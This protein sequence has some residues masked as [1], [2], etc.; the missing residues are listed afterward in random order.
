MSREPD[1]KTVSAR[2]TVH[3]VFDVEHDGGLD[4]VGVVRNL[5]VFYVTPMF[6]IW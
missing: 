2:L 5:R 4:V 3:G 6:K 1:L